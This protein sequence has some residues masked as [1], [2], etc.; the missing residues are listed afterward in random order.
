MK[1]WQKDRNYRKY[2]NED[3]TS[4]YI[5]TVDGEDVEI[6]FEIYQAYAQADRKE[7][8][9]YEREEGLVISLDRMAED[10]VPLIYLT[11][12]H[13]ESAEDTAIREMMI[14]QMM[15]A[16]GLLSKEEQEL[17]D[18]LFFRNVSARE[19]A[20]TIG[21]YHR[22]IIYRRDKVLEKL[23]RLVSE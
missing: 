2:Q 18:Q 14:E 4:H 16:V 17:I 8:Y 13:V 12:Q 6:S 9:G 19:L 11:G 5:I 3:G 21:V 22:S 1:Y 20:R 23:R 15:D 7:R 10:G